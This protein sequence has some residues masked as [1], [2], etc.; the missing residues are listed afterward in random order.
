MTYGP[1]SGWDVK[2]VTDMSTMF[3]Q[4]QTFNEPL[5]WDTSS[6]T[7]V[8]SMFYYAKAFNQPLNWDMSSVT[9]LT[10]MFGNVEAF[11]QDLNAWDVSSVKGM[12]SV[13]NG[14]ASFN[15]PLNSWD[16]SSVTAMDSAFQHAASFNQPLDSWDT[17]S[18]WNMGQTFQG[19]SSFNQP[20]GWD[21]SSVTNWFWSFRDTTGLSDA[22]RV[23]MRCAWAG[24]SAFD[25]AYGTAW[26]NLGACSGRRLSEG[27]APAPQC[28]P[29]SL[30]VTVEN[31]DGNQYE[32]GGFGTDP[33]SVGLGTYTFTGIPA[34]HPMRVYDASGTCTP[35]LPN[36]ET[37]CTGT[38]TWSIPAD[39]A[40]RTL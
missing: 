21:T 15:H 26:S 25:A 32:L 28:L 35:T 19:A 34:N 24:N 11:N 2:A 7:N 37:Y 8:H 17:S 22:N 6:V 14:A 9:A 38:C 36:G 1:I 10:W 30:N 20:L 3:Q 5:N 31:V 12:H 29:S 13:F 27:G 39:C 23:I 18:V 16:V 4:Y 40:G 33:R